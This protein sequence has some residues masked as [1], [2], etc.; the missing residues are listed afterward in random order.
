MTHYKN[1]NLNFTSFIRKYITKCKI[2]P[3]FIKNFI[4]KF[5]RYQMLFKISKKYHIYISEMYATEND[6]LYVLYFV[7]SLKK[8][9]IIL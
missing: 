1:L 6:G 9:D 2:T 5:C 4:R 7:V 3:H 8:F